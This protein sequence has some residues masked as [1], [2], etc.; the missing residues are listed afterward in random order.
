MLAA[1]ERATRLKIRRQILLS[2]NP[3]CRYC[4][5]RLTKKSATLDHLVPIA[6]GGTDERENL[7]LACGP[8]NLAKANRTPTQ[9]AA[10]ILAGCSS[11]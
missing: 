10:D 6:Q 5:R 7:V 1:F 3:H 4:G 8:V 2:E 9:W 11:E